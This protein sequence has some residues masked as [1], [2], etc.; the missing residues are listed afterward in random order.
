[1]KLTVTY[2]TKERK[3]HNAI[4]F[5]NV[6][7]TIEVE[8]VLISRS[9]CGKGAAKNRYY[10]TAFFTAPE[11]ALYSVEGMCKSRIYRTF[12]PSFRP[13]GLEFDVDDVCY[14]PNA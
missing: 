2:V 6:S 3:W 12:N 11:D 5:S 14:S 9:P 8:P 1:M 13:N 10:Y 4:C 7:K